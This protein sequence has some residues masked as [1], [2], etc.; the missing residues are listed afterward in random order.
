MNSEVL[1]REQETIVQESKEIATIFCDYAL[2][3][4]S[5]ITYTNRELPGT[6][7]NKAN[8]T[9]ALQPSFSTLP[10][11]HTRSLDQLVER[12]TGIIILLRIRLRVTRAS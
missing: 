4:T 5:F 1:S 8:N 11:S 9:R 12:R 2:F 7:V 3:T 10:L 6:P